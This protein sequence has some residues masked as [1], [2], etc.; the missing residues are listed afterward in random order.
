MPTETF[1]NLPEEKRERILNAAID[2]FS[3][4]S[5]KNSS[6][7]KIIKNA[8]IPR[9]SFYQYF[10]DIKDFYKYIL[11]II[12]DKK[13]KYLYYVMGNL[14]N[15]GTLEIIGELYISGIKF[16]KDNPKLAAIGNKF[17]K[18]SDEVKKE[19][20]GELEGK[21][22]D[23]FYQILKKGQEKGDISE[24]VDIETAAFMFFN[25]NIAMVDDFIK[26]LSIGGELVGIDAFLDKADKILYIIGNG[27]KKR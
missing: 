20:L 12:G 19:F 21:S 4:Q 26:G 22:N 24:D 17:L 15:L 9:G 16:A 10:S 3:Q 27:I 7:S 11:N 14:D 6:V 23:F 18:E 25:M 5:I 8:G 13:L 2:E 1:F